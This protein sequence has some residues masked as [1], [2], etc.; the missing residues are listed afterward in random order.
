MRWRAGA[1]RRTPPDVERIVEV[2]ERRRPSARLSSSR[3]STTRSSWSGSWGGAASLGSTTHIAVLDRDGWACSVTCSNGSCSGVVV[4]GTGLHLNNMLGEQDLNPLGFHRHPPGRRLPSMMAPDRGAA[5]RRARAGAGQRGIQPDPLGDP[6]DDRPRDR[7]RLAGPGGGR[8]AAGALRGRRRVR[9]TWNRHVRAR[10][11]GPGNRP[12]PGAQTCSSAAS[13][14]SSAT[15][16]GDSG[17]AAIRGGAAPRSWS[18]AGGERDAPAPC[19]S[20]LA[21]P[22]AGCGLNVQAAGSVPAQARGQG[23]TADTS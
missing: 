14:R 15:P 22:L 10:A 12:L 7:R 20:A 11:R 17:A 16:G 21:W 13:R 19:W 6:A 18:H 5:R 2:M 3:D 9:R 8:G 4:P 1:H 23:R